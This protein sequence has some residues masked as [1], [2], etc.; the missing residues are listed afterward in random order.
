MKV[1][2][3]TILPNSL[4]GS[5][6]PAD[7][8][9]VY[10]YKVNSEKKINPD[11]VM[12]NFWVDFPIWINALFK[13]RNFLV[14]FAGLKKEEQDLQELEKCIRMG[15][16]YGIASV[17][18]KNDNETVLLL[19]DS[20]L[21]AYISVYVENKE[22]RKVVSAIT[23]VHFKNR[24]GRIYFFIVRP[25]HGVIVKSMLKRAVDKVLS[26]S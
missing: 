6:L 3:A 17:P 9:D 22:E 12:V 4:I 18:A 25:F 8:S 2:N 20:H 24:F 1:K 16:T 21:D 11:D 23:L 10:I 14:K 5:Y 26:E 15:K 19:S 13:L 7:Y